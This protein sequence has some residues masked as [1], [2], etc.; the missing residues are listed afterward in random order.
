MISHR[1]SY[2]ATSISWD[3]KNTGGILNGKTSSAG[4]PPSHVGASKSSRNGRRFLRTGPKK[5][6][7]PFAVVGLGSCGEHVYT[8]PPKPPPFFFAVFSNLPTPLGGRAK[9]FVFGP[10]SLKLKDWL[11]GNHMES[12]A[13]A[14]VGISAGKRTPIGHNFVCLIYPW[15]I[16]MY[17]I[18]GNIYHQYTPNASIYIYTIHGSYGM[19]CIS[20]KDISSWN[21]V[22]TLPATGSTKLYPAPKWRECPCPSS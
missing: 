2:Q 18:Y 9:T 3:G 10:A 22:A 4:V 17:T 19:G 6:L 11:G 21:Y 8:I 20:H 12:S 13:L 14:G 1:E 5:W 16:R 15:R 7:T